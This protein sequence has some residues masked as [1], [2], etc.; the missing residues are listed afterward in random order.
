MPETRQDLQA[1]VAKVMLGHDFS[2][3]STCGKG[4][5]SESHQR[6]AR[7]HVRKHF[8][9]GRHVSNLNTSRSPSPA[10]SFPEVQGKFLTLSP[11]L[12]LTM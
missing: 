12:K 11:V 5:Y 4:F 9:S 6:S 2:H 8:S 3:C 1:V 7:R 10:D